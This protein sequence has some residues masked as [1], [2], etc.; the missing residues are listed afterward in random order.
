MGLS[1]LYVSDD[2][3]VS[4]DPETYQDQTNP[5][6]PLPGNYRFVCGKIVAK[7]DRNGKAILADDK[8]PVLTV[9][10]VKI[11]EPTESEAEFG[12]FHDIRTKP[13]DRQGS[14]VSDL[15]DITRSMDQTRAWQGLKAGLD[16]FDELTQGNAPFTAQLAWEA[17]DG[18]FVEKSFDDLG[19]PKGTEKAALREGR[20][21]EPAYKAIY[22]KARLGTEAFIPYA[23]ADGTVTRKTTAVGPSGNTLE[24][25]AKVKKFFPSLDQTKL[26]AFAIKA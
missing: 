24:A 5:A 20:I 17:Y 16:T 19:I 11:V 9:Q 2:L 18:A 22:K 8:Y 6:P 26:G 12:L 1:D 21:T 3:D 10:R 15:G 13:Y 7:T 23:K 4:V 14:V 25:K